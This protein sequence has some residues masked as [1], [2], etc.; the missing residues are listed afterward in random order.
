M[1]LLPD[2]Q[3]FSTTFTELSVS[4]MNFWPSRFVL[5]VCKRNEEP[6]PPNTLY[7]LVC[8]LQRYLRGRGHADM[9]IFD[10]PSFHDFRSTLDG[11]MKRTG[12]YLNKKQALPITV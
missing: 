11:E 4:E 7:Q 8:G 10:T 2:E 6:Y 12:N 3:P 9:K 5:E 1:R